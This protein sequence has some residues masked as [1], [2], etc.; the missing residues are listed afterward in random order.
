MF[1]KAR[2][3]TVFGRSTKDTVSSGA[4]ISY[5][6]DASTSHDDSNSTTKRHPTQS[7]TETEPEGVGDVGVAWRGACLLKGETGLW[8]LIPSKIQHTCRGEAHGGWKKIERLGNRSL[9]LCRGR[10][11]IEKTL[12]STTKPC[13]R[14]QL[15]Q[16]GFEPARIIALGVIAIFSPGALPTELSPR[17]EELQ[18]IKEALTKNGYKE[19]DIDRVCRTHRTKVKQEPT[20]PYACL[21][22]VSGVTDKL[23]KTLS[24]KNIGVRFR[25]VKKIQQVLPSKKD[26][27]PRL[28]TKGVYEL[29][30]ICGKSYIGQTGRSIQCRIK[31][32]QRHTRLGNIDK[33]AIAEYVH[34]NENHKIDYE[35]IRVLDKTTRF[36]PRIIRESLEIMKNNNN[37]NREDGYRLSNPWRLAIPR[38]SDLECHVTH[39]GHGLLGVLVKGL[40][41]D[42]QQL[43]DDDEVVV[44]PL[45]H[46]VNPQNTHVVGSGALGGGH[47]LGLPDLGGGALPR[48]P[49]PDGRRGRH[50]TPGGL[51]QRRRDL[52]RALGVSR[53][54]AVGG[55]RDGRLNQLRP[56][57]ARLRARLELGVDDLAEPQD[58]QGG[59]YPAEYEHG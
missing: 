59:Q 41:P 39:L 54:H 58:E 11:H 53:V 8:H 44:Q 21:P 16:A 28:L 30:Y 40:Y 55:L 15:P 27:V 6:N 36:Y 49:L 19:K 13:D 57:L 43:V 3:K 46:V 23:K 48:Q 25:T 14:C 1:V 34:T 26:P 5:L 32:H 50:V 20:S 35:N 12:D 42:A 9:R 51:R 24:K 17:P 38:T 7:P 47:E 10:I 4:T 2:S 52:L 22:Y 56:G 29:K 45:K 31:E 37:F 33:S 18:Q